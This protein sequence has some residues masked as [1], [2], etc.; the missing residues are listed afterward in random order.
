M[1]W[2]SKDTG[3][4]M[5]AGAGRPN[6]ESSSRSGQAFHDEGGG[7]GEYDPD[8]GT[9]DHPVA[10]L[11]IGDVLDPVSGGDGHGDGDEEDAD[12]EAP[13]EISF[14]EAALV[15][16]LARVPLLLAIVLWI[17][18]AGTVLALER[19]LKTGSRIDKR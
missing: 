19:F 16:G 6:V 7:Q 17:V 12:D 4:E 11:P 13:C 9:E 3:K 8:D 14:H 2:G 10:V 18:T 1:W 15:L 5:G